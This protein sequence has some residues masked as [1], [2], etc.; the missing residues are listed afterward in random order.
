MAKGPPSWLSLRV[1]YAANGAAIEP[2]MWA[3]G[4]LGAHLNFSDVCPPLP[5]RRALWRPLREAM[6]FK[7]LR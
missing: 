7:F 4:N 1:F 6:T 2:K 5:A 3:L